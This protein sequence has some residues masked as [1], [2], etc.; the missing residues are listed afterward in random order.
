VSNGANP[1]MTE[2]FQGYIQEM[3]TNDPDDLYMRQLEANASD[4]NGQ[5]HL[6]Y[7]TMMTSYNAELAWKFETMQGDTEYVMVTTMVQLSL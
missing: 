7:L 5:S 2:E 1:M 3:L 6:G 4:D